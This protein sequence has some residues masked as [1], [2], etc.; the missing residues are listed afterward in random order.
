MVTIIFLPLST[1]SSIFGMNSSDLRDMEQGQWAYWAAA[2]PTTIA[3]IIMGLWWMGELR[4][5]VNWVRGLPSRGS[6]GGRGYARVSQPA[7]ANGV[8]YYPQAADYP[9]MMDPPAMRPYSRAT[10]GL[11]VPR[12]SWRH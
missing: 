5:L 4:N 8:I 2:I 1:I 11:P 10:F 3:V 6:R 12:P 7:A 9:G